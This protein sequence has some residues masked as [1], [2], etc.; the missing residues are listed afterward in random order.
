MLSPSTFHEDCATIGG[1]NYKYGYR[2]Q[3]FATSRFTPDQAGGCTFEGD[4]APG[5]PGSTGDVLSVNL[6]FT[7]KLIDTCNG[8]TQL[9]AAAW[10]VV[11]TTTVP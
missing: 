10:S 6:D 11:G 1:T 3:R 8:N 5:L 9:A 7:G 2:S 4:D